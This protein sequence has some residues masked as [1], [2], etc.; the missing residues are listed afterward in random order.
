ML[1]G[2]SLF[3][4]LLSSIGLQFSSVGLWLSFDAWNSDL[5]WLTSVGLAG[6]KQ[7]VRFFLVSL[8]SAQANLADYVRR[9]P[10]YSYSRWCELLQL[11]PR[12]VQIWQ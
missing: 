4:H 10:L 7:S 3:A 8:W 6:L 2:A 11:L 9:R 1:W 12:S 5:Y